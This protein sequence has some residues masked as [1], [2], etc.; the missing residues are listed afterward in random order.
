MSNKITTNT[1]L[2]VSKNGKYYPI[3]GANYTQLAK[4]LDAIEYLHKMDVMHRDIKSENILIDA[5][6]NIKLCDFGW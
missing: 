3:C 6:K 4:V 5:N 1:Y 2:L